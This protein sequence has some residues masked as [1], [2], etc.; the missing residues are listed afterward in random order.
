VHHEV[1]EGK[2]I[3]YRTPG[4]EFYVH[5]IFGAFLC[6]SLILLAEKAFSQ[7]ISIDYHRKQFEAKIRESKRNIELLGQLYKVSRHACRVLGRFLRYRLPNPASDG[8]MSPAG[9]PLGLLQTVGRIGGKATTVLASTAFGNIARE[10]T[11]K[12]VLDPNSP[13]SIVTKALETDK[14]TL[15]LAHRL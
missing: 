8:A 9:T 13:H 12:K 11:E 2:E 5:R 3:E 4:W 15:A 6:C 14:S 10:I 1:V 7:Y